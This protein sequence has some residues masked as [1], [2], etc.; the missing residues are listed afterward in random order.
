[1]NLLFIIIDADQYDLA[2]I[3]CNL[4]GV[5]LCFDLFDSR[6]SWL[7]VFQFNQK[8]RGVNILSGYKYDIC[9]AFLA[10]TVL[11]KR[12]R[13]AYAD[14]SVLCV[15]NSVRVRY[16]LS[17]I[18]IYFRIQAELEVCIVWIEIY[19]H[20]IPLLALVYHNLFRKSRNQ[21]PYQPEMAGIL[22]RAITSYSR[23][24]MCLI[25]YD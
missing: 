18:N 25:T 17:F 10:A 14:E 19:P 20:K 11:P 23:L 1:M 6:I 7:A 4:F 16:Q 21:L 22:F 8:G 24:S 9:K 2:G 5:L 15:D 13:T 12:T 3:F